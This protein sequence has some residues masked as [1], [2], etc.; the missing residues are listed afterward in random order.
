M[1]D[2]DDL[3]DQVGNFMSTD[4]NDMVMLELQISRVLSHQREELFRK[5][6]EFFGNFAKLEDVQVSVTEEATPKAKAKDTDLFKEIALDIDAI[7]KK[8]LRELVQERVLTGHQDDVS[9]DRVVYQD[10][11]KKLIYQD[12]IT[13]DMFC[14]LLLKIGVVVPDFRSPEDKTEKLKGRDF[15]KVVETKLG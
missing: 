9:I 11:V 7:D 15:R 14:Y 5:V 13:L 2:A 3:K 12:S 8:A 6:H 4:L 10:A 1:A